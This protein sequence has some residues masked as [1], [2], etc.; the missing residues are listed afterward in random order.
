M[1]KLPQEKTGDEVERVAKSGERV[2]YLIP[3]DAASSDTSQE[4]GLFEYWNAIWRA[5]LLVACVCVA[6][7]AAALCYV[8]LAKPWYRA[9][10]LLVPA[11]TKSAQGLSGQ[12]SSIGGLS[13]LASLA[14]I[15]IGGAETSE[16]LAVLRSR[17]FGSAFIEDLNLLPVFFN[18]ELDA[19]TGRWKS[20][21]ARKWPDIRDGYKF[22]D[23]EVRKVAEDKKTSLVT[24]SI[25]WT[26]ASVA[27]QW[28]NLLVERLNDRLRRRAL[29]EAEGNVAYLRSELANTNVV[30]LQQS[31]GRLLDTELQK[32]M[33]ARGTKEFAYRVVDKAVAPKWRTKPRRLQTV[34]L[35][36]LGGATLM[37]IAVCANYVARRDR[38]VRRKTETRG[39]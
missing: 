22:F 9:D 2:F 28:A 13:G 33:L 39:T 8:F 34:L 18:S 37:V 14:G 36:V 23:E 1:D 10:V 38:A 17:E 15:N 4:I 20:A 12:L 5:R 26:D 21:D 3:Q 32:V 29:T 25:E 16:P 6:C 35:S 27:A 31:V 30:G 11:E 7:G 24:L 19:R